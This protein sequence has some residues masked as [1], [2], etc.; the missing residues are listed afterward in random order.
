MTRKEFKA[1]FRAARMALRVFTDHAQLGADRK[2]AENQW[3][4]GVQDPRRRA[5]FLVAAAGIDHR[6]VIPTPLSNMALYAWKHGLY[7]RMGWRDQVRERLRSR[8]T[9]V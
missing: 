9:H 5:G 7:E 6:R 3:I 8:P 2:Q 4:A 1:A